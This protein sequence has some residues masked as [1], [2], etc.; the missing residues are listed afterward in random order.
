LLRKAGALRI[1]AD[2]RFLLADQVHRWSA[3]ELGAT[4]CRL[5]SRNLTRREWQ[6]EFSSLPYRRTCAALAE[7]PEGTTELGS[8]AAVRGSVYGLPRDAE[9]AFKTRRSAE[10]SW[11]PPATGCSCPRL[12]EN[13]E[14]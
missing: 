5:L 3:D 8:V 6:L 12:C 14:S 9:H 7:P 1:T 13:T 2:Q 11:Q 4:A 10:R